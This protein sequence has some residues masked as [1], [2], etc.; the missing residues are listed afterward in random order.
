[1]RTPQ[2]AECRNLV[3]KAHPGHEERRLPGRE[4]KRAVHEQTGE[5]KRRERK[6]ISQ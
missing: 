5:R 4:Q 2:S 1:M 3:N 6:K